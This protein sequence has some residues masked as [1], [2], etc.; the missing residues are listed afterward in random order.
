MNAPFRRKSNVFAAAAHSLYLR[1]SSRHQ[2]IF[3]GEFLTF[4][5]FGRS[6]AGGINH[7]WSVFAFSRIGELRARTSATGAG[8]WPAGGVTV[9]MHS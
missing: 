1:E 3:V 5:R 4:S 8:R 7:N 2:S 6:S 9:Q